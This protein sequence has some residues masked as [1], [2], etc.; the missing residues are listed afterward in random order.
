MEYDY[1]WE[2]YCAGCKHYKD[3]CRLLDEIKDDFEGQ[4]DFQTLAEWIGENYEETVEYFEKIEDECDC[5]GRFAEQ[6]DEMGLADDRAY[7]RWLDTM[8]R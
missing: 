2:G 5:G 3:G 4:N 8:M 1:E 7:E 6:E